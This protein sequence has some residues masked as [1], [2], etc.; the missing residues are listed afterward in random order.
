[1]YILERIGMLVNLLNHTQHV[2]TGPG[3]IILLAL[4]LIDYNP[5][6]YITF[7]L[8]IGYIKYYHMLKYLKIICCSG[9]ALIRV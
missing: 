3:V 9:N 4:S 5:L 1:M 6:G 8:T 2:V 7:L